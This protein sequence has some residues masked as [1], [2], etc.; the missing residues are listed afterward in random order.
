MDGDPDGWRLPLVLFLL[1][2]TSPDR[3]L[4]WVVRIESRALTSRSA[5][6]IISKVGLQLLLEPQASGVIFRAACSTT[7][8]C[9]LH[10]RYPLISFEGPMHPLT[11]CLPAPTTTHAGVVYPVYASFQAMEKASAPSLML[12]KQDEKEQWLTYWCVYGLFS[13]IEEKADDIL[14]ALPYYWH[15]K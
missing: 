3:G 6:D 5:M 4:L 8:A 15:A 13:I 11:R 2:P 9:P 1:I 10:A 14:K 12:A 7:G